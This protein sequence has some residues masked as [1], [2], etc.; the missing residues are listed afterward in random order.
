MI[1]SGTSIKEMHAPVSKRTNAKK[2]K[3]EYPHDASK[4]FW[5]LL[6]PRSSLF[7][8]ENRWMLWHLHEIQIKS[9]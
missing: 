3:Q 2:R 6:L 7:S 1:C 4:P 5:V 8:S 9:W